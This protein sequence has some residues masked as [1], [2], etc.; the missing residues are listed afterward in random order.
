MHD[1]LATTSTATIR[2]L[3][4]IMN[5]CAVLC[6]QISLQTQGSIT[7]SGFPALYF[8]ILPVPETTCPKKSQTLVHFNPF[9]PPHFFVEEIF[10]QPPFSVEILQQ[11]TALQPWLPLYI[12]W[13]HDCGKQ[14]EKKERKPLQVSAEAVVFGFYGNHQLV[15]FG[16]KDVEKPRGEDE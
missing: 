14:K 7:Q 10:L 13:L 12:T 1:C 15:H 4:N 8:I 2:F 9:F 16:E 5:C 3:H 6:H 11:S